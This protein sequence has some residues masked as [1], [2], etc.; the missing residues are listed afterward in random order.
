MNLTIKYI[1][2]GD[3][4]PYEN[5]SRTHSNAQV[6]QVAASIE[7]FGFTNP[8][9]IDPDNGVIAGHGRLLAAELLELDEVPTIMLKN[10][11]DDQK[12]AYVIADNK[13]ALNSGWDDALLKLELDA[14]LEVDFDLD[15]LGWDILPSFEEEIDYS[16]LNDETSVDAS[17]TQE[18]QD[19]STAVKR[20]IMIEFENEHYE[21]ARELVDY[22]RKAGADVGYMLLCY[23]KAEKSKQDNL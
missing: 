15:L 13:I 8:I 21:E 2:T 5:N 11:T 1:K 12:K 17:I 23:L 7:E 14:L 4:I 16:V 3:L 20:A 10:L 9:L 22:W 19:M 18:V 6:D